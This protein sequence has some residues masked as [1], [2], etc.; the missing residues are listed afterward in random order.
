M[1]KRIIAVIMTLILALPIAACSGS[2]A[3]E[4]AVTEDQ[5]AGPA[6]DVSDDVPADAPAD[7]PADDPE[8]A[9][10]ETS[11]EE[12]PEAAN[13]E[14]EIKR[15][16]RTIDL[17]EY[18]YDGQF[19]KYYYETALLPDTVKNHEK[20]NKALEAEKEEFFAPDG[21][22]QKIGLDEVL[23]TF[24]DPDDWR[25]TA[26]VK[27]VYLDDRY[28]SV[29]LEY[30]SCFGGTDVSVFRAHTFDLDTGEEVGPGEVLGM[31]DAELSSLLYDKVD[32]YFSEAVGEDGY[33]ARESFLKDEYYGAFDHCIAGDGRVYVLYDKNAIAAGYVGSMAL[34]ICRYSD[35]IQNIR[36]TAMYDMDGG[37]WYSLTKAQ[38]D[39]IYRSLGKGEVDDAGIR[40]D[41]LAPYYKDAHLYD[42]VIF[43]KN[44]VP[45]PEQEVIASADVD[46]DDPAKITDTTDQKIRH[47][48]SK[49]E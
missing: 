16:D 44:D 37:R 24:R 31:D 26:A 5:D 36:H 30:F 25:C 48:R 47:F 13:V 9:Q 38:L 20:I 21:Y 43:Y 2:R 32:K 42:R 4:P 45:Y 15:D 1:E 18:G 12:T 11:S 22:R 28:Y 40:S 46:I 8:P 23:E 19:L 33:P 39:E 27:S 17:K 49:T 6:E 34:Y 3:V 41:E 7:D 14:I 29:N 10:D 35:E